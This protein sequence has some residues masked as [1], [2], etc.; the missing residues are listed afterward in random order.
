MK[1]DSK[2]VIT[3][4]DQARMVSTNRVKSFFLRPK[5]YRVKLQET[6]AKHFKFVV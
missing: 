4:T 6:P 2:K 1:I 5:C 3:H